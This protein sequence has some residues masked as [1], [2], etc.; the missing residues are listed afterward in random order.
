MERTAVDYTRNDTGTAT[1][2]RAVPKVDTNTEGTQQWDLDLVSGVAEDDAQ[3]V[4][5]ALPQVGEYLARARD[6]KGSAQI[7]IKPTTR[8]VRVNLHATD[9][10][11]S[12]VLLEASAEIRHLRMH[13]TEKAQRYVARLRVYGLTPEQ[14]AALVRNLGQPLRVH[15]SQAQQEFQFEGPAL[16]S[17]VGGEHQ[18][19]KVFGI[20]QQRTDAGLVID[21]FGVV[22][23]VPKVESAIELSDGWQEYARQYGKDVRDAGRDPTWRDLILALGSVG[24]GATLD[25]EVVAWAVEQHLPPEAGSGSG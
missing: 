8:D 12:A 21:D 9:E 11:G 15:V 5:P 19:N 3:H 22:Y 24:D 1:L 14:G 20:L 4:A 7:T 25:A 23:T 2:A 16:G 6:G 17:L 18:G 13:L 10:E